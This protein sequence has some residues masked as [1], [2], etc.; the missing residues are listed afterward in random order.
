[1]DNQIYVHILYV[2]VCLCTWLLTYARACTHPRSRQAKY[3]ARGSLSSGELNRID[4]RDMKRRKQGGG[5]FNY[6]IL[7]LT[8][9]LPYLGTYFSF[10]GFFSSSLLFLL[11]TCFA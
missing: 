7:I 11:I 1:M 8:C 2:H 3:I 10:S 9:Q 6:I 4:E 5:V